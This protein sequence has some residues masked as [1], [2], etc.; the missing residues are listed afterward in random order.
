MKAFQFDRK[1]IDAYSRFSRSFTRIRSVDLR[2]AVELQYDAARFW[3]SALLSINPRFLKGPTVDGLVASGDLDEATGRIFRFGTTP[4]RFYRHQSEAIAKARAGQSFVVT[5]GTASGKSLCFFVQIVDA[6]IRE[7]KAGRRLGTSA[8]IIYPMNALANSQ[9]KEI[10]KFISQSGLSSDFRPTVRR[11]TGQESQEHRQQIAHNPPDILLTNFMMAELL[12]TRQEGIDAKIIDNAN[13]LRFIVLD[14]LHTYRGRQGADVAILVRRL[15]NRC[16]PKRPPICIG[17]SATMASEGPE[18][19]RVQAV[20]D[21]AS[22]L[23]GTPIGPDAV[24][25]ESL[26]RAT[27]DSLK[28]GDVKAQLADVL[29]SALPDVL[30]DEVLKRHPLAVWTEL[31]IGL[32]DGQELKRKKPAPFND[33]VALLASD[34]GVDTASCEVGFE[35][36]L[37]H[38]SLAEKERGGMGAGAFLAFKLTHLVIVC[39]QPAFAVNAATRSTWSRR[40]KAQ[41]VRRFFR[42]TSTIRLLTTL[43]ATRLDT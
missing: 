32:D 4:L 36:F 13:D 38:V 19:S 20:A 40:S 39:I 11:C 12:L 15:R 27:D 23:F 42:E 10:Q 25:D 2:A 41:T 21:S 6:I 29:T 17:T 16:A 7:R 22:R 14:E 9:I 8:I 43:T 26:E 1:L 24:I 3:P 5:T 35:R 33:A 37:T 28:V 34:S 31:S 18:G 30:T